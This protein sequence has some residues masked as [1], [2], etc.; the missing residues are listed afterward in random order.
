MFDTY[1]LTNLPFGQP[2]LFFLF[3]H[4]FFGCPPSK[5]LLPIKIQRRL[6]KTSILGKKCVKWV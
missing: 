2:V 5:D 3:A 1:F 4:G 6:V